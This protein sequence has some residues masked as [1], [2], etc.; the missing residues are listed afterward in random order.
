MKRYNLLVITLAIAA[1]ALTGCAAKK[2]PLTTLPAKEAIE[3]AKLSVLRVVITTEE[4]LE[5]SKSTEP[6]AICR[7]QITND[8]SQLGFRVT[9]PAKAL[10]YESS[11]VKITDF[12]SA[13][14]AD[15]EPVV[16]EET[17]AST[18]TGAPTQPR[19][20]A[21]EGMVL[22]WQGEFMRGSPSS[23]KDRDSDEGRVRKVYV[24]AFYMDKHEVTVGQFKEFIEDTS[25]QTDAEKEGWAWTWTG[26]KWEKT[27]GANWRNPGFSQTNNHPVV[28]VSWNDAVAYAR[29]VGK[30]LPT[31]AEW[32]YACRARTT[33]PF[34]YGDSLS[35][36]EA[37]FNGNYPYGGARKGVYREKTTP[38]GS[39]KPNAFGLYDMH[40][41]VWEWCSDW[42]G[43]YPSGTVTDPK[44]PNSGKYRVLRGGSWYDNAGLCRSA[45]RLR[46]EPMSAYY[47]VGFRCAQTP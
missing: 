5:L 11:P 46:Y 3:V 34:H 4:T 45:S 23:E 27:K 36:D 28:C 21:P 9:H 7:E 31:E 13:L 37:N 25:F 35:S 8:L 26:S 14:D 40:G 2:P 10:S 19:T 30:R 33:T 38:V 15:E 16:K 47:D 20:K 43:R 29:W 12:A 17:K 39:F 24:D 1:L 32:E 44:G 22:I 6:L 41:N 42:Y 18:T